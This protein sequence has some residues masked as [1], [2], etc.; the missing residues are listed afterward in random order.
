MNGDMVFSMAATGSKIGPKIGPRDSM[1]AKH[2]NEDESLTDI[3]GPMSGRPDHGSLQQND[4]H[5]SWLGSPVYLAYRALLMRK[6]RHYG[7]SNSTRLLACAQELN[8]IE[9][10]RKAR[11]GKKTFD[12]PH[13]SQPLVDRER[14]SPPIPVRHETRFGARAQLGRE[15]SVYRQPPREIGL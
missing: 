2:P 14:K 10:P 1:A 13:F 15:S 5:L 8:R 9:I 6:A 11:P 12:S 3:P 7:F 4:R